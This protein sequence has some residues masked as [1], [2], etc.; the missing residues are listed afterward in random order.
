MKKSAT[1][2]LLTIVLVVAVLF[3]LFWIAGAFDGLNGPGPSRFLDRR[4]R[5]RS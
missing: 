3:W 5:W 4:L 1:Q 2:G